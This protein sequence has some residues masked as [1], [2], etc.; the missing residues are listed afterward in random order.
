MDE[1]NDSSENSDV[2]EVVVV[3]AEEAKGMANTVAEE[4]DEEE[5]ATSETEEDSV[6]RLI[7]F[8]D[9]LLTLCYRWSWMMLRLP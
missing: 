1:L 3:A 5:D 6:G 9:S 7:G 4:M 2:E 8:V